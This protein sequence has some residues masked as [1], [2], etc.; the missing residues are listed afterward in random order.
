MKKDA[1]EKTNVMRL[2]DQKKAEYVSHSYASTGA[3]SGV[4]VAAALGQ[5]PARVFKTLVTLGK[6]GQHYVFVI[7]VAKE[8]DLKKAAKAAGEKSIEMIKSKELLPLT[9]YIHGGCSPIGMKKFFPT[10]IDQTAENCETF[11]FSA[12]KIG[13]QIETDPQTLSKMIRYT[14]ADLTEDDQ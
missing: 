8:L 12:G 10:F 3:I 14:L 7:P 9:G 5:D 11:C 13:Y 2:L 6:T 1:I 4:D